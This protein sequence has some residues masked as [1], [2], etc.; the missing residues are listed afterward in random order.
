MVVGCDGSSVRCSMESIC[1]SVK[2]F[3]GDGTRRIE[4]VAEEKRGFTCSATTP[5]VNEVGRGDP[6][7]SGD[8]PTDVSDLVADMIKI[9]HM[10]NGI[11]VV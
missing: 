7:D 9:P 11:E 8:E 2:A 4:F 5:K 10:W 6:G 1:R 3:G